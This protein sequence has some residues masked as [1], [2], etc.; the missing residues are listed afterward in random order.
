MHLWSLHQQSDLIVECEEHEI[1]RNLRG[2]ADM[3]RRLLCVFAHPDDEVFCA[4]GSIAKYSAQGYEIMVVSVTKGDAG[5]IRDA[6]IATRKTLGTVRAQEFQQS[7]SHLGVQHAVCLDYG[8]GTLQSLE[9]EVLVAD[10]VRIIREYRP[11]VV[12]TFGPDGAYGHPDHIAIGEATTIA[13]TVSDD[14]NHFPQQLSDG[15]QPFAPNSLYHSFFPRSRRLMLQTLSRWLVS[16]QSRTGATVQVDPTEFVRA[17]LLF[18]EETTMLNYS[19]DRID[20]NWYPTGFYIIEQG[21]VAKDLYLILSG[22]AHAVREH[23][24]GTLE[25]LHGE[26]GPGMFFGELGLALNQRRMAHVIA[27]DDVTCLVMSMSEAVLFAGRGSD[28]TIASGADLIDPSDAAAVDALIDVGQATHCIDVEEYVLHKIRAMSAHRS[29]YPI[30]PDMFP[31]ELVKELMGHEYFVQV[32]P[33]PTLI[34][35]L[36]P[37]TLHDQHKQGVQQWS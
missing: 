2:F 3:T 25:V 18:T 33:R 10:V 23:A 11:E 37:V 31:L 20:I 14:P 34:D 4:G 19:S 29:Q 32:L 27:L 30:T 6:N 5:Q 1:H 35:T 22:H 13:C 24:D 21:E 8:D 36:F 12:I 9:I 15:L 26:L 28:A 16:R 17:L 7:C